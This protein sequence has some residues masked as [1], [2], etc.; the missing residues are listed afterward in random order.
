MRCVK[1]GHEVVVRLSRIVRDRGCQGCS[2][3]RPLTDSEAREIFL[4]VGLEPLGSYPGSHQPWSSRCIAAGHEVSPRLHNVRATGSGC[5]DCASGRPI[6]PDEAAAFLAQVGL[7]PLE[8]YP[9]NTKMPW[10]VRCLKAGHEVL[11]STSKAQQGYGCGECSPTRRLRDDEAL[12]IMR[13]G[14][15]EPIGPYPGAHAKWPSRCLSVG[16]EVTPRVVDVRRGVGCA[17]CY[18]NVRTDGAVAVAVMLEAGYEPL[19]P[20]PG[21]TAPWRS[22]CLVAGHETSPR[23]TAVKSKGTRC[24]VCAGKAR[25]SDEEARAVMLAAGFE[26][27][28]PY[29]GTDDP[30]PSVC[31]AE[32]HRTRPR[33]GSV[34]RGGRCRD[35]A[36]GHIDYSAPSVLYVVMSDELIKLG[37]TNTSNE[38]RRMEKHRSQGLHDL[39]GRR[40]LPTGYE[41]FA[42]ERRWL[43][44]ARSVPRYQVSR[45]LLADGFTEALL[46]HDQAITV[47]RQL[48]TEPVPR[49]G[50]P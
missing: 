34:L 48:L 37:I 26:P 25:Y 8:P 40:T 29:P 38:R 45:D 36:H 35:C 12:A 33:Y 39:L 6:R 18:G 27:L 9:G 50:R 28:T 41:A 44:Y 42:L 13:E 1:A 3:F 16:H 31:L 47:A 21:S 24:L 32:G 23:F 17:M 30:W 19:E 46:L 15:F 2:R 22:R 10:R 14:G 4:Q 7:E 43:A 49:D 11:S 20:Y 5:R